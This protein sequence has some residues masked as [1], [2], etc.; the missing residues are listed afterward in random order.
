MF[1]CV[2][3]WRLYEYLRRFR[4]FPLSISSSDQLYNQLGVIFGQEKWQYQTS[5]GDSFILNIVEASSWVQHKVVLYFNLS[6][7]VYHY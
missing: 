2:R 3:I 5:K 6:V 1:N 4:F 7:R